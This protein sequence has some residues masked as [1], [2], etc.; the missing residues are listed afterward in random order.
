MNPDPAAVDTAVVGGGIL[1]LATAWRLLSDRPGSRVVVLE[2]EK[3]VAHHQSGRNSNVLHA[4]VYY[5]PGSLKARTCREGKRRMEEFLAAEGLPWRRCGKL[6]VATAPE[7]LPRLAELE[8]RA[9]ANG[10][11]VRPLGAEELREREPAAAG[12]RALEVPESGITDYGAVCRRLAQRI[13]AA[14]GEVRLGVRVRRIEERRGAVRI[15]TT[16]GDLE[17]R[18]LVNCAGLHSDRV[19][20]RVGLRPA[21]RIVPFRG[22]FFELTPAARARAGLE[23]LLYPVPDPAF[24]FLGV[25]LTPTVTGGLH[26]G[27]NAVPALAREGYS[28]ARVSPVDLAGTLTW[29]GTWRLAR[30]FWRTGWGEVR[31]SLS[32][33]AFARALARLLPGTTAADLVPAPAGVRA[34]ALGRDGALIDDFLIQSTARTVHVLNAPSPAATAAFAIAAR[35]AAAV[36]E[37]RA[38]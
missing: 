2:K 33:R 22:E 34:Q 20:A 27:P 9:A 38:G 21:A 28:W 25:H 5:R 10:V 4:G 29:P 12:I 1:G 13:A 26:C 24:P 36:A 16:A 37:R 30:R 3:A 31:R 15:A 17:A 11:E 7:E 6:I 32:R 19:A 18:L 14:G 23:R 8:R 35:V